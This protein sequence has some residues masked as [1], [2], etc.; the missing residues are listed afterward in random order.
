MNTENTKNIFFLNKEEREE[1]LNM[2]LHIGHHKRNMANSMK[3]YSVPSKNNK[4]FFLINFHQTLLSL[5][6]AEDTIMENQ[7]KNPLFVI[8]KKFTASTIIELLKDSDFN[9]IQEWLPGTLTN[10]NIVQKRYAVYEEI[11]NNKS[12]NSKLKKHAFMSINKIFENF[13][14]TQK[15]D[16]IVFSDLRY[17][18]NAVVESKKINI[19]TIG[20]CDLDCC[21]YNVRYPIMANDDSKQSISLIFNR[22]INAF[23]KNK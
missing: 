21:I 18:Y 14:Y 20:I 16:V 10:S 8:I 7:W 22:I 4:N 17:A 5:K 9:Y 3:E 23:K 13:K 12:N 1:M 11:L 19:P 6:K 15:P 2:E